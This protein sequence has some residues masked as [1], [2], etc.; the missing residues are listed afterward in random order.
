MRYPVRFPSYPYLLSQHNQRV[1]VYHFSSKMP[2]LGND[3]VWDGGLQHSIED[4][5]VIPDDS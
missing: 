4:L 3:V 1:C 2:S 5:V